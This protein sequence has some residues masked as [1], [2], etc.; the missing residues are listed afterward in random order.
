MNVYDFDQT[1]YY[2]DSSY[3]FFLWCLKKHP[4]DVLPVI[5]KSMILALRYKRGKVSAKSL[6][7][8]LF[9]FLARLNDVDLEVKSFWDCHRQNM[10]DWYMRQKRDDDLIIS[11]SPEFLLAPITKELGVRL[12]ATKM[13]PHTGMIFGENC[14]DREKVLRFREAFPDGEIDEF[15]SDSMSD[16]PLADLAKQSYLVKKQLLI[17]WPKE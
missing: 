12:I 15:Y 16:S 5:P 6:K 2:P 3:H 1:V 10:Q 9:S 8:Q 7:Q 14:H 4:G 11:A 13:D 17:P